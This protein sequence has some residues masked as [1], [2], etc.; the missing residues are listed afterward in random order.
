MHLSILFHPLPGHL[1]G[2]LLWPD[3]R[4]DISGHWPIIPQDAGVSYVPNFNRVAHRRHHLSNR[5]EQ[6][7]TKVRVWL[8]SA[9]VWF[10]PPWTLGSC[11]DLDPADGN[12]DGEKARLI[13]AEGFQK[14]HNTRSRRGPPFA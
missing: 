2:H 14:S 1:A 12:E 8:G 4:A 11:S 5:S 7:F 6:P 9:D 10:P 13:F 3:L